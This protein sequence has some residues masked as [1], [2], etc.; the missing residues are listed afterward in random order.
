MQAVRVA[1]KAIGRIVAA[2][3]QAGDLERTVIIVTSDHGGSGTKHN[4]ALKENISIPWI[5]AGPGIDR[6]AAL[7]QIIHIQDTMPTILSLL[8]EPV[9]TGLSGRTIALGAD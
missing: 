3:R 7:S 2:V 5:A 4:K 6:G 1:D 9:P 8:G